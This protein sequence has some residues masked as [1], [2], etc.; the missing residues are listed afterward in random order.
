MR[1]LAK[2]IRAIFLMNLELYRDATPAQNSRGLTHLFT[3]RNLTS[4]TAGIAFVGSDFVIQSAGAGLSEGARGLAVDA[5]VAAHEIGHNFGAEH[6]GD[7]TGSCPVAGNFI[8][9]PSVNPNNEDFSACSVGV[10]EEVADA[11][12]CVDLL[13]KVD[14]RSNSMHSRRLCCSERIRY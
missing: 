4:T 7:P 5:L 11:A 13:P 14:M 12:L 9:S 6:D 1:A 8:M 10:M 2:L 3:G